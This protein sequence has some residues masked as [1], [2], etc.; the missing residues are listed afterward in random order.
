MSKFGPVLSLIQGYFLYIGKFDNS[1]ILEIKKMISF[2][3]NSNNNLYGYSL[4]TYTIFTFKIFRIVLLIIIP[5]VC[6]SYTP[7]L[8][9]T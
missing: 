2:G 5:I 4:L 1:Y 3:K 6:M 8:H 7:K 9:S